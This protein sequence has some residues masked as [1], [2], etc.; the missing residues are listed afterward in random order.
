M[1]YWKDLLGSIKTRSKPRSNELL[2][3]Y[4]MAALHMGV[5]SYREGKVFEFDEA[6]ETV[7]TL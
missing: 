1:T 5:R 4:V 6:T 2:G 3:Y 7:K